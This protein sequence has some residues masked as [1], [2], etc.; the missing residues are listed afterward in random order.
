MQRT[1]YGG[2]GHGNVGSLLVGD[3]EAMLAY[4][5][6]SI[7]H[8]LC[9]PVIDGDLGLVLGQGNEATLVGVT[10]CLAVL[11]ASQLGGAKWTLHRIMYAADLLGMA[12]WRD[13]VNF[14]FSFVGLEAKH[15]GLLFVLYASM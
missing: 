10:K 1:V 4:L 7:S 11:D 15:S 2:G 14:L 5:S 6:L 9:S 3:E 13:K 12:P 8:E